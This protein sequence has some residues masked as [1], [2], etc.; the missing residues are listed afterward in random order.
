MESFYCIPKLVVGTVYKLYAGC[1]LYSRHY[2]IFYKILLFEFVLYKKLRILTD[3]LAWRLNKLVM[4][5]LNLTS[6]C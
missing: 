2:Q 6:E 1:G 3:V 4:M 5:A